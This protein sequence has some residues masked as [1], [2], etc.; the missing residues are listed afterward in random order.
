MGRADG[1]LYFR[2]GSTLSLSRARS[3]ACRERDSRRRVRAAAVCFRWESVPVDAYAHADRSGSLAVAGRHSGAALWGVGF[4]V[5]RSTRRGV[6]LSGYEGGSVE[7]VDVRR[8]HGAELDS[9]NCSAPTGFGV[10]RALAVRPP[11]SNCQTD[12]ASGCCAR[13]SRSNSAWRSGELCAEAISHSKQRFVP[14]GY[15]RI[16]PQGFANLRR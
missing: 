7:R 3:A 10:S 9:F 13:S 15:R 14:Y 6:A 1:P 5:P 8:Q 16:R 4:R 12:Q 2:L 11:I